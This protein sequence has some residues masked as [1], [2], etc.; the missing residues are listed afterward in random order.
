MVLLDNQVGSPNSVLDN[1]MFDIS[2]DEFDIDVI[3]LSNDEEVNSDN[4]VIRQSPN[5]EVITRIYNTRIPPPSLIREVGIW[6]KIGNSLSLNHIEH[7][8][9]IKDLSEENKNMISSINEEIKLI[10]AITTN[11]SRVIEDIIEQQESKD[12]IKE[13]DTL[14]I[15]DIGTKNTFEG[16]ALD[17]WIPALEQGEQ[18]SKGSTNNGRAWKLPFLE[19]KQASTCSF[20][21]GLTCTLMADADAKKKSRPFFSQF[22]S[23]VF[24]KIARIGLAAAENSLGVILDEI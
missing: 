11:M 12:N 4:V 19:C 3:A 8:Y 1:E 22:L 18:R 14:K 20:V 5:E 2:S 17:P 16:N 13:Y 7:G 23:L 15:C 6:D 21:F 10:L 9:S 24:L